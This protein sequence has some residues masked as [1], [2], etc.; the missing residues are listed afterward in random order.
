MEK[1]SMQLNIQLGQL[2]FSWERCSGRKLWSLPVRGRRCLWGRRLKM[3]PC[4][5]C[6]LKSSNL[7]PSSYN[8]PCSGQWR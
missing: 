2:T 6:G 5:E 3:I 4:V 1:L 8:Q 7:S